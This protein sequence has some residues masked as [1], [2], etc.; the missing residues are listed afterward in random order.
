MDFLIDS[1]SPVTTIPLSVWTKLKKD[2]ELGRARIGSWRKG[3]AREL[4]AYGGAKTL[5]VRCSFEAVLAVEG[6]DKPTHKE[7]IYVV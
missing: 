5:K 7:E 3:G 4:R 2:W 1:G 6:H